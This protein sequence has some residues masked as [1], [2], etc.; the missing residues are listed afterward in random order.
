[1]VRERTPMH[2]H[3]SVQNSQGKIVLSFI[4]KADVNF[5]QAIMYGNSAILHRFPRNVSF[6]WL[7]KFVI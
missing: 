1:M 5:P 7:M 6:L 3:K 2:L 4:T